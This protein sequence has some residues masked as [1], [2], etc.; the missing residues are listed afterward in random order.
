MPSP[1]GHALAGLAA[2][3]LVQGTPPLK[4]KTAWCR[5]AALFGALGILPDVDLLF[6]AH[7]GPTHGVGAAFL[8]GVAAFVVWPGQTAARARAALACALAYGSH[9]L[10]DWLGSDSSAPIGIMVLWPMSR[11]YYESGL[12]IFMAISRRYWQGA[13]FW[14]QNLTALARE[15]LVLGPILAAVALTRKRRAEWSLR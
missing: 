7:S 11:E 2:G 15:L 6:H 10:L 4:A 12:N 5:E 1:V 13:A 14:R 3:W 8:V 9:I